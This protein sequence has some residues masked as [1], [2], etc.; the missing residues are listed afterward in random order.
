MVEPERGRGEAPSSTFVFSEVQPAGYSSP[1]G[2]CSS[3][4]P[5]GYGENAVPSPS[6][7]VAIPIS[8]CFLH[9]HLQSPPEAA[10]FSTRES[11]HRYA[12]KHKGGVHR[13]RQPHFSADKPVLDYTTHSQLLSL[14][15]I[16]K[17][18]QVTAFRDSKSTRCWLKFYL[19]I[20][21]SSR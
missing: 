10:A 4:S 1:V 13:A 6:H 15:F 16:R 9:I 18:P 2:G 11:G 14:K 12:R 8:C 20:P 19:E 5:L 7:V 3:T 17:L 21:W